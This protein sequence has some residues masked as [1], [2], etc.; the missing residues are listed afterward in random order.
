MSWRVVVVTGVAKLDLKMGFLVVRKDTT[1]RVHLSEIH[2]LIID[3][4]AVS[5][6]AAEIPVL[7][8]EPYCRPRLK[9]SIR[10]LIDVDHC[11]LPDS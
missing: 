11:E 9:N 2:T 5:L 4:T 8:V 3:S 6:T 7:F 1:T 10:L